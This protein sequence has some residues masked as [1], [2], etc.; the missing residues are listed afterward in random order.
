MTTE[1]TDKM[2][3]EDKST[4]TENI[5]EL[6]LT[7]QSLGFI[8]YGIKNEETLKKVLDFFNMSMSD[9][10]LSWKKYLLVPNM[11]VGIAKQAVWFMLTC[12]EIDDK[13]NINK[14]FERMANDMIT[15][16]CV[17]VQVKA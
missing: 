7:A 2:H 4:V 10:I 17:A 11:T 8:M 16:A 1:I 14:D 12:F 5:D 15:M 6:L 13:Q 3:S 9:F